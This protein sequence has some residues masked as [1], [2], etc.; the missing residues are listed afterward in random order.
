M[1]VEYQMRAYRTTSGAQGFVY[2]I[3]QNAPDYDGSVWQ[4]QP[5][6]SGEPS[7]DKAH[8]TDISINRSYQ[9]IFPAD[10]TNAGTIQLTRDLGGN[11]LSPNVV[12]LRGVDLANDPPALNESLVYDGSKW[13]TESISTAL[14]LTPNTVVTANSAGAVSGVSLPSP[15]I[16]YAVLTQQN[17]GTL[18]FQKL[19]LDMLSPAF[20]ITS[21][22]STSQYLLVVGDTL[23][24]P[25]FNMVYSSPPTGATIRVDSGSPVTISSP[26]T[27]Y[28]HTGSF[29]GS[30]FGDTVNFTVQATDGVAS[31]SSTI[32]FKWGYRVYRG[33]AVKW[34]DIATANKVTTITGMIN[35]I[36]MSRI[37]AFS[38]TPGASEYIYYA[39]PA[40]FGDATFTT[41]L[42]GGFIKVEPSLNINGVYYFV[43]QSE[44]KN[45]GA[46]TV[47]VT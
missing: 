13:I 35:T 42:T 18:A 30:S 28:A 31:K 14:S 6:S 26:F 17:D 7:R 19:S 20:S 47:N 1:A 44:Q 16:P 36:Q 22:T 23:S 25:S 40:S 3:S 2:W 15:T 32:Q 43:Y 38:V 9:L 46:T 24:N 29:T 4:S 8:L 11:A 41:N 45:L 5:A 10:A 27:S 33:V 34:S 37:G 12:G 21:F 39:I